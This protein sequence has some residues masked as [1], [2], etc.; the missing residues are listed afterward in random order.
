MA[1]IHGMDLYIGQQVSDMG[2]DG[3]RVSDSA[4]KVPTRLKEVQ[5]QGVAEFGRAE[6]IRRRVSEPGNGLD[7]GVQRHSEFG[8]PEVSGGVDG[9]GSR[10]TAQ[11]T[12][13]ASLRG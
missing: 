9:R 1:V 2:G 12:S 4:T 11:R 5:E 8:N 6:E 10:S 7:V 3:F 13:R